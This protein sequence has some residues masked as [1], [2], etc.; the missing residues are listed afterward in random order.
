MTGNNR[1]VVVVML[2]SRRKRPGAG[3]LLRADGRQ[4]M[5]VA[6][7][8]LAPVRDDCIYAH[9]DDPA[10]SG[11]T[12][13]QELLRYN[14]EPGD[15][16]L[17]LLPAWQLYQ[18]LIYHQL[19]REYRPDG[20]YILSA[21]WG[22]IRADFLTPDYDITFR[23]AA[24]QPRY[25]CRRWEDNYDDW[26]MLPAD[27]NRPMVFFGSPEYVPL[28]CKLTDGMAPGRRY[29]FYNTSQAPDAPGC[30]LRKYDG[31]PREWHYSAVR[32][33]MAGRIGL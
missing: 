33:F 28:F 4:V 9:P 17:G 5:F 6:H 3:Q 23:T 22:L 2:C 20:L 18:N 24:R 19:W 21:G 13:R 26:R 30:Q 27:T 32:D 8:E 11:L 7:P 12:W 31:P 29:V 15:N 10:D 16:P 1:D 14:Q 25:Q